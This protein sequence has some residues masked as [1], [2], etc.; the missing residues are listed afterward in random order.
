ML[1]GDTPMRD[2]LSLEKLQRQVLRMSILALTFLGF[3]PTAFSLISGHIPRGACFPQIASGVYLC[4]LLVL[5][6]FKRTP[7]PLL[8]GTSVGGFVVIALSGLF[9]M[10]MWHI[11]PVFLVTSAFVVAFC[12]GLTVSFLLV[13]V[14]VS[15]MVLIAWLYVTGRLEIGFDPNLLH[16]SSSTWTSRVAAIL[17]L[18]LFMVYVVK[19][20]KDHFLINYKNIDEKNKE[21]EV[22]NQRLLSSENELRVQHAVLEQAH[23]EMYSEAYSDSLTGL[24]NR[25]CFLRELTNLFLKQP[26]ERFLLF[27]LGLDRFSQINEIHGYELGDRLLKEVALRLSSFFPEAVLLSRMGDDEYA[28]FASYTTQE[29]LTALI[30]KMKSLFRQPFVLGEKTVALSAGIGVALCENAKKTP[31]EFLLH[32]SVAMGHS[33]TTGVLELY[34]HVLH[35]E[36]EKK[37][38]MKAH[39]KEALKKEEFVLFYQPLLVA[40]TKKL[41]GFEALLRWNSAAYGFLPPDRFLPILEETGFIVDCGYW[42]I[43]EAC[44][45]ILSFDPR[46]ELTISINCSSLQLRQ[47]DFVT[48]VK[49]I[50]R[51]TG[52]RVE[53]VEL[54]ITETVLIQDYE[55]VIQALEQLVVL[56]IR[57]ALDD[58]GVGYSSLNYLQQLPIHTLKID[59]SFT[60]RIPGN[61]KNESLLAAIL[62]MAHVLG[63][64]VVAEGVEEEAQERFLIDAQCDFLQG[65]LYGK[66]MPKSQLVSWKEA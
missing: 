51:K 66:P 27:Y 54:E 43:E 15:G 28:V 29:E 39:V 53:Q 59:K 24:I 33:K 5:L 57:V 25:R 8:I 23:E 9:S 36:L 10:G 35:E 56:G 61:Q 58:F 6:F 46:G 49:E 18:M 48:K 22:A 17:G 1:R 37:Y 40:K 55:T 7:L 42:V 26:E 62:G 45:F 30:L 2:P 65:Y 34:S 41:R 47:P 50:L 20:I 11:A 63:L 52:V 14:S 44:R 3:V 60:S 38:V 31:Q 12:A 4:V 13:G 32:A 16:A 21:L 64:Q 19:M